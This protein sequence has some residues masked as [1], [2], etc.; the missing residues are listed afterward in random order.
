M[1]RSIDKRY[2]HEIEGKEREVYH[3]V[4]YLS[5]LFRG[6]QLNWPTLTKEA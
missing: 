2:V 6:S 1:G 3:P 4:T 5:G